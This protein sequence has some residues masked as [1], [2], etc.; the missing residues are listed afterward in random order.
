M[1]IID[2]TPLVSHLKS[3]DASYE[4]LI[5]RIRAADNKAAQ[6]SSAQHSELMD[7]IV[8]AREDY[9]AKLDAL[10]YLVRIQLKNR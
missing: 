10:S 9:I 3:I 4:N 2:A 5:K 1:Q 8:K 6:L 7:A